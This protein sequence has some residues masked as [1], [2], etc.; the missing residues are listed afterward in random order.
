MKVTSPATPKPSSTQRAS[1]SSAAA[2]AKPVAKA[3]VSHD[4]FKAAGGKPNKN[5]N[6]LAG[7]DSYAVGAPQSTKTNKIPEHFGDEVKEWAAVALGYVEVAA[8]KVGIDHVYPVQSY[9]F[10]MSNGLMRGSRID[11][12]EGYQS[13]RNN[14]IK[15]IIDLREEGRGDEGFGAKKAGLK[16]L[17]IPVIDNTTPKP[18]Q[19]VQFLDFVSNKANQPVYFHC[20][21]GKGRTGVFAAC[22][23][24]ALEGWTPEA[25]LAEAEK[26]GASLVDQQNFILQFGRDLKA[27][28]YPGYPVKQ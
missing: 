2:P 12:L 8:G 26:F 3:P 19:V 10:K 16:T 23:R 14:G 20:E 21:A 7:A 25:A 6:V 5:A 15:S 27:G 11:T 13:L 17:R 1:K 9:Q 4:T 18:K 24:M 22:A 28:K